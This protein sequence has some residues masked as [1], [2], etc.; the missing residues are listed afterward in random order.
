MNPVIPVSTILINPVTNW[1]INPQSEEVIPEI[2]GDLGS[3]GLT[4]NWLS[5]LQDSLRIPY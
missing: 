3:Q 1:D 5:L 4:L 2:P